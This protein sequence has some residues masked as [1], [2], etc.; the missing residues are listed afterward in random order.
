MTKG[1]FDMLCL[2][3]GVGWGAMLFSFDKSTSLEGVGQ[4][5]KPVMVRGVPKNER[6]NIRK[7]S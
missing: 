1:E 6:K 5:K 3:A 2:C 4:K 7:S